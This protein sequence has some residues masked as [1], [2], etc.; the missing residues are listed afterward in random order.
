MQ[1]TGG[2]V[3]WYFLSW[4]PSHSHGGSCP[5][6]WVTWCTSQSEK[7]YCHMLSRAKLS[8]PERSM[9][10]TWCQFHWCIPIETFQLCISEMNQAVL[11][12]QLLKPKLFFLPSDQIVKPPILFFPLRSIQLVKVFFI[13]HQKLWQYWIAWRI[14][15]VPKERL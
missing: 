2:T 11:Q 4:P 10:K 6:Y 7:L 9:R 14:G 1:E 15:F 3:S 8:S 12:K 5:W 13:R